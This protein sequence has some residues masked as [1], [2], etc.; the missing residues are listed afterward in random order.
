M[1]VVVARLPLHP[2]VS[3]VEPRLPLD[4]GVSVVPSLPFHLG[5]ADAATRETECP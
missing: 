3:V 5:V 1:V 2:G 4:L